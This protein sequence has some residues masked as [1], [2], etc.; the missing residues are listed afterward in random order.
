M[1]TVLQSLPCD[2]VSAYEDECASAY[3]CGAVEGVRTIGR[4]DSDGDRPAA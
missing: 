3:Y 1:T 4:Q 2:L